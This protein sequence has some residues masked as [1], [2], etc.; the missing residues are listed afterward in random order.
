[1]ALTLLGMILLAASQILLR[2]IWHTGLE[3]S[4]PLLRVMVLWLALL[5]AMAAAREENH[6]SIDV[7]S[8]FLP[9]RFGTASRIVTDLFAASICSLLAWHA[10][11][12]VLM[13]REVINYAFAQVPTWIC[14]LILP[15]GFGVMALRF[16]AAA[17][18]RLLG[19]ADLLTPPNGHEDG[20]A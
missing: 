16:A 9:P 11:R 7:L 13:E 15:V 19:R 20:T 14:E 6:I 1:M 4:D 18:L 10:G 17:A 5:G 2:N 8:R 3:W 12:F